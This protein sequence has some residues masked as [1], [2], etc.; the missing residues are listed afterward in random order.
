MTQVAFVLLLLLGAPLHAIAQTPAAPS[1]DL[2]FW[3]GLAGRKFVAAPG[4]SPAALARELSGLLGSPDPEL[5]DDIGYTGLVSLI[6][7][8]R[9]VPADTLRALTGD[10]IANL[11]TGVGE[12]GTDTVLKRSFSALALGI[13]AALDNESPELDRAAFDRLLRAALAYS[14]ASATCA[15]TIRPEAGCTASRTRP[16]C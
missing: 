9:V 14:M 1:R 3:R 12:Q 5:R 15:G 2:A 7:R 4:E 10:W 11:S 8:Q 13:V 6:F 16:I